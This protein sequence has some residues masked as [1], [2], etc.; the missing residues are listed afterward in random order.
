MAQ[1]TKGIS[2]AQWAAIA[3]VIAAMLG[4]C[5]TL[6]GFAV[7]CVDKTGN[8][9]C[10]HPASKLPPITM[11]PSPLSSIP[12]PTSAQW[13]PPPT[14]TEGQS[15][16]PTGTT[17]PDT[18]ILIPSWTPSLTPS[19]TPSWTPIWT[20]TTTSTKTPL[21]TFDL[22]TL[23]PSAIWASG[24][25]PLTF[26]E[27]AN[28]KGYVQYENGVR[29][30]DGTT[31]DRILTTHPQ[32]VDDGLIKGLYPPYTIAFEDHFRAQIGYIA[33]R[34]GTCGVRSV[35]FQ[36][37]YSDNDGWATLGEWTKNC[38]Y[39]LTSIDIDLSAITGKTVQFNPVVLTNG[40][41]SQDWAVWVNPRVEH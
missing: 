8:I 26:G 30:E 23:A 33:L 5:G 25:G 10:Y 40:T 4:L 38:D 9:Y 27:P 20:I 13:L 19:L 39:T 12:D 36:L 35:I 7:N 14:S 15:F 34:D 24:A 2:G 3:T 11:T 32:W 29:L 1:D 17:P 28:A 16:I 21:V 6:T 31:S 41:A 18:P 37:N 22:Y